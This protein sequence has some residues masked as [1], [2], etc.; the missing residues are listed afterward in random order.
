ME[1]SSTLDVVV[2]SCEVDIVDTTLIFSDEVIFSEVNAISEEVCG[3]GDD[4]SVVITSSL[5]S[6]SSSSNDVEKTGVTL[7]EVV[8]PVSVVV[9]TSSVAIDVDGNVLF[10]VEDIDVSI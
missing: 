5:L 10:V 1:I 9:V 4:V 2:A 7:K 8:I 3:L 6:S